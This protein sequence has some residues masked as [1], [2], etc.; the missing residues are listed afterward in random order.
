MCVLFCCFVV[1]FAGIRLN[2]NSQRECHRAGNF[3]VTLLLRTICM[4]SQF[5]GRPGAGGVVVIHTNKQTRL[6]TRL[7]NAEGAM[8]E[9]NATG[10]VQG[11]GMS[12]RCM[13]GIVLTFHVTSSKHVLLLPLARVSSCGPSL[14]IFSRRSGRPRMRR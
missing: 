5:S 8:K 2:R 12:S 1:Y 10:T 3:T 4:H 13:R 14:N 11:A 7:N 9:G 6:R